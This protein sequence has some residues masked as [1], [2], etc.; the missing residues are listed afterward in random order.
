M[1]QLQFQ[2]AAAISDEAAVRWFM[3]VDSAMQ[4]WGITGVED[5]AM[6]IAQT[7][8]ESAGFSALIE[9]FNYTPEGLLATFGRRITPYQA[10]MLGR[11]SGRPARQEAIARLV[12]AGR[13][14]NRAPEDGWKF[15]GR[16]LIQV[17]GLDNYRRCGTALKLDLIT[18]PQLLEQAAI[19]AHSAA[20]FYVTHGCLQHS[21]DVEKVTRMINGGSH[22]LA[23][24]QR[25]YNVALAAME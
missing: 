1:N 11:V 24:R 22:G 15:R 13:L 19:A 9:S 16:G 23:D 3:P 2:C 7:G 4:A 6:F 5:Q 18:A 8:H 14:G 21:G 17:T 12:Y 20:W 10:G 25:R